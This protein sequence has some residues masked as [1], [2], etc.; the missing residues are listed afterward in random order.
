MKGI[1]GDEKARKGLL[2]FIL[3]GAG[4]GTVIGLLTQNLG[5]W[6]GVGAGAG[7]LVG[8]ALFRKTSK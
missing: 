5:V 6:I 3:M 8:I 7:F 2:V 1:L 4:I